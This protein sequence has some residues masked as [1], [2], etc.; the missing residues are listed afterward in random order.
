[1]SDEARVIYL[2]STGNYPVYITD[3][4]KTERLKNAGRQWAVIEW[5]MQ[6][7]QH[8]KIT[9]ERIEMTAAAFPHWRAVCER[10]ARIGKMMSMLDARG[11]EWRD[12]F[13]QEMKPY[14]RDG[15]DDYDAMLDEYLD[16]S[17]KVLAEAVTYS[18]GDTEGVFIL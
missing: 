15:R 12:K 6:R 18:G 9:P 11:V 17:D 5:Y 4:G 2:N 14:S 10:C 8:V 16:A 7:D 3:T 13:A 1:M